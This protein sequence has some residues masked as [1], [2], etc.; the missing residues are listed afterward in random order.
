M[1]IL[2]IPTST[3]ITVLTVCSLLLFFFLFPISAPDCD[4]AF[5]KESNEESP[6][7][8]VPGI[9]NIHSGTSEELL[10]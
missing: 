7:V 3:L 10:E 4:D 9:Y 6:T 8:C 2:A 5:S 1:P